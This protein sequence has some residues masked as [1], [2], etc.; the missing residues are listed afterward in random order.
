MEAVVTL[1]GTKLPHSK[2]SCV[3]KSKRLSSTSPA[4]TQANIDLL[5]RRPKSAEWLGGFS[6]R[7]DSEM[8]VLIPRHG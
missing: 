1:L 2:R 8:P 3:P 7:E 6:R 4:V 5:L